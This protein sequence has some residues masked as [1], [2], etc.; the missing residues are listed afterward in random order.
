MYY[1]LGAVLELL[2]R[3]DE[4]EEVYQFAIDN[5]DSKDQYVESVRHAFVVMLQKKSAKY[6][7]RERYVVFPCI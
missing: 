6:F 3:F 5:F 1:Q 4:A 7:D 2:E